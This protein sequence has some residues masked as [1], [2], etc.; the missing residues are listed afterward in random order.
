MTHTKVQQSDNL[1]RRL[2]Q[3]IE[4]AVCMNARQYT[5]EASHRPPEVTPSRHVH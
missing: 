2:D 5:L 4:I 1:S 3:L